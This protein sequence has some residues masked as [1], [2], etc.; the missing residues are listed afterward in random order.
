M[1]RGSARHYNPIM[2]MAA[3]KVVAEVDMVA[4]ELHPHF[5]VTP[6]IFIDTIVISTSTDLFPRGDYYG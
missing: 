2:A 5:I 3:D 1:Y 4:D 6:G